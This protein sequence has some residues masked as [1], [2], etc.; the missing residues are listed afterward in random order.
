[1]QIPFNLINDF[2]SITGI[3]AL[4]LLGIFLII[5]GREKKLFPTIEFYAN[6]KTWALVAVI[7]VFAI[8]YVMGLF[9]VVIIEPLGNL[10]FSQLYPQIV[11]PD[12][13][14]KIS[15]FNSDI[16]TQEFTG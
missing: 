4:C 12:L 13:L 14:A 15:F 7:P 16:L 1:M 8:S 2:A 11:E 9:S 5:D 6:T 10:L 3:G